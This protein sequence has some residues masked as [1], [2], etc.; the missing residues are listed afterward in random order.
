MEAEKSQGFLF[1]LPPCWARV[2]IPPPQAIAP[3]RQPSPK[4]TALSWVLVPAPTP[5]P[6]DLGMITASQCCSR[7]LASHRLLLVSSNLAY[8]F[9]KL[10]SITPPMVPFP[11]DP[12]TALLTCLDLH[13]LVLPSSHPPPILLLQDTHGLCS[14]IP[15]LPHSQSCF[16]RCLCSCTNTSTN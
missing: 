14:T 8:P 1:Q 11:P 10:S 2:G 16:S 3:G 5:Y 4:V 12:S 9:I 15:S 7:P 6:P 13:P